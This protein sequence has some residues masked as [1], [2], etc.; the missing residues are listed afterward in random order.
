MIRRPLTLLLLL[1]TALLGL[2]TVVRL[3]G[4]HGHRPLV[5]VDVVVPLLALPLLVLLGVQLLLRRTRLAAAT[6]VLVVLNAC[7]LVPRYW[8]DPVRPGEP[9]TV[10]T[11]N[12][13]Y[14]EADP[15]AVVDL[16][17]RHRVDVFAAEELT[18]AAVDLLRGAGLDQALPHQRLLPGRG[19]DGSG[20][21]SRYPLTDLPAWDTRF[22]SPGALVTTPGHRVVV[23]VVHA[24]PPVGAEEGRYRRDYE[25][26]TAD[27]RA[28]DP[29]TPLV[30]AG[31]FNASTDNSLLRDLLGSRL[32]DAAEVA[33]DGVQRTWAVH[34]GWVPLLHL[35]HVLVDRHLDVRGTRVLDVPGSDHDA[36]L[37][38]LVLV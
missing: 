18:P 8:G 20:L 26:I 32:R 7:W 34:P 3:V 6:A 21:W 37:A 1:A 10:L 15:F 4:D 28:L 35:D 11:L 29:A 36:V 31:D 9:L 30:L 25:Q 38:R 12:M 23:R 24:F 33:G 5:L 13:R 14:G 27:V 2:P 22:A 19:P 16:V 17:R